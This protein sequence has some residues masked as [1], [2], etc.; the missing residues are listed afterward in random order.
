MDQLPAQ[1]VQFL[2]PYLPYL[3]KGLKLAG[4]EA[5]KK[6]G[7]KAGEGGF[8]QAKALWDRLRPKVEARPAALEAAQDAADHPDDADAL[9]ALRLQLRKLLA[10]DDSL[11]QELARLLPQSGPA[12][13]TV[14]ASGERS[15]AIGGDVSGGV[16]VTGDRNTVQTGKYNVSIG[17]ASG[18]TIG[19]QIPTSAKKPAKGITMI[20]VES[21]MVDSVGYDEERHLLQVVFTSG[22]VYCYEDVP[23]EVFQGL[24]EAESKGQYMR[25]YIIDVY[26]YRRGPCRKT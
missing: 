8:E 19:D 2:A 23:P 3:V 1:L 18:V 9:A 17:Q 13:Q 21:S 22:R 14:V 12:G 4:Q 25:A 10:E 16:I 26:P 6:L 24:L 11:A 15:V 5:A 20:P 7:E